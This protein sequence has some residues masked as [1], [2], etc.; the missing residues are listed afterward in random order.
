MTELEQELL[1]CAIKLRAV[2]DWLPHPHCVEA[3]EMADAA[4]AKAKAEEYDNNH[5]PCSYCGE[6]CDP[7]AATPTQWQCNDCE[8]WN[9]KEQADG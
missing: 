9:D 5:D 8:Q 4:I 6:G 2:A 3:I 7:M 1:A